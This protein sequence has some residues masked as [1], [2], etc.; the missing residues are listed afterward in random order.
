MITRT[1]WAIKNPTA[2]SLN[3]SYPRGLGQREFLRDGASRC[4]IDLDGSEKGMRLCKKF[5]LGCKSHVDPFSTRRQEPQQNGLLPMGGVWKE[6][7]F[8]LDPLIQMH[9]LERTP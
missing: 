9:P 1:L 3:H 2:G 5:K 8:L 4:Q 6:L 7:I